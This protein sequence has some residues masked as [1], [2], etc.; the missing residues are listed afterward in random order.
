METDGL[1]T[2]LEKQFYRDNHKKY[3]KYFSEF[4]E[5]VDIT[6]IIDDAYNLIAPYVKED[7]SSFC[8][9]DKFEKAVDTLKEFC[10]LRTKSIKGQIS[11]TIPSTS[12]GQSADSSK[13][14]DASKITIEKNAK[15][16]VAPRPSYSI[17][18]NYMLKL[19]TNHMFAQ[20]EDAIAEYI[21]G[22]C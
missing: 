18:E 3:H 17:L 22:I 7:V 1:Y 8:T 21:K 6:G 11:G 9:Y 4:I 12:S 16:T 15:A 2:W 19:T 20:W 13:L 14:I 10:V 5:K